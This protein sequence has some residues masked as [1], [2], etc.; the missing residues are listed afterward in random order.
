MAVS[1]V[2]LSGLVFAS[3]ASAQ[4]FYENTNYNNNTNSYANAG[5]NGATAYYTNSVN[6]NSTNY[7][8]GYGGY[9]NYGGYPIGG[10]SGCNNGCNNGW[11]NWNTVID[12][13]ITTF[14]DPCVN[15]F[16]NVRRHHR[17]F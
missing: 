12:P 9:N 13:C 8:N 17:F 1:A 6:S 15:T 10:F 16:N 4:G 3:G 11:N 14:V 7:L 2:V 5:P